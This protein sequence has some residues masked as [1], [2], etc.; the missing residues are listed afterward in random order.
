MDVQMDGRVGG[1][2][3]GLVNFEFGWNVVF[4]DTKSDKLTAAQK[5]KGV[6]ESKV[7]I[8]QQERRRCYRYVIWYETIL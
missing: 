2:I 7:V 6:L 3:D 5:L 4:T 8:K 1:W